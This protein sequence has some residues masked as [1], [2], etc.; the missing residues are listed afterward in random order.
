VFNRRASRSRRGKVNDPIKWVWSPAPTH[1]PLIPKWMYDELNARRQERRGSRDSN[2]A[3]SHPQTRHTYLMRG[4][5]FHGCGRRMFGHH[6][7]GMTY[8]ECFP[9]ANN[10]G[11]PDTYTGHVKS[12][13]IREDA[14]LQAVSAFYDRVFGPHRRGPVRRRSGY[15][16]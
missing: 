9:R 13:Y 7:H 12:A 3:N 15:C 5:L 11:R 1:E 14:V 2:T 16:R 6:R 4:M 8:Y 10:R